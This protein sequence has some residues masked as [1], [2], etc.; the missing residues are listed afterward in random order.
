ME[1]KARAALAILERQ[2]VQVLTSV[3]DAIAAA[4]EPDDLDSALWGP[5]PTPAEVGVAAAKSATALARERAEVC[6][7]SLSR[8]EAA[9]ALGVSSQAVSQ[10]LT[11]ERLVGLRQGREWRFPT[12]QFS[13]RS[14][15]DAGRG[16]LPGLA[17]LVEAFPAGPVALSRWVVTPSS[18]L[19]GASPRELLSRG[20]VEA[21]VSLA[22]SLTAAGW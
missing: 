2:P 9:R 6:S 10:M 18:D 22:R 8:I 12:W 19:D 16:M 7:E 15:R 5:A 21:V 4:E 11:A 13:S 1:A 17:E 14:D 20:G 3:A